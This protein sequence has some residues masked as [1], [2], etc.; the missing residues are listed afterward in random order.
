VEAIWIALISVGGT[1]AAGSLGAWAVS[2]ASERER[3][4]R[5]RRDFDAALSTFFAA[6]VKAVVALQRMPPYDPDHWFH[7][8]SEGIEE[9]K[10][11]L[12]GPSV[13]WAQTERGLRQTLGDQPFRPFENVVDAAALVLVLD[14]GP[15]MTE[16]SDVVLE[17][18]K[19]LGSD[20]SQ[21]EF[22]RWPAIH[23]QLVNAIRVTQAG[24]R[25]HRRNHSKT[26]ASPIKAEPLPTSGEETRPAL[27]A[28]TEAESFDE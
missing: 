23:R 28:G 2:R 19:T 26:I 1:L 18:L 8:L 14:P 3:E 27:P 12:L 11:R 13:G 21:E 4:D 17:Y 15:E 9:A 22:D 6:A 24:N 5:R 10:R 25:R 16:A 7:Q 20:R